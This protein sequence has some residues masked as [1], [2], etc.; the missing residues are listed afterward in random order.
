MNYLEIMRRTYTRS[1]MLQ[2]D[3]GVKIKVKVGGTKGSTKGVK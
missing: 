1:K 3:Q 2:G